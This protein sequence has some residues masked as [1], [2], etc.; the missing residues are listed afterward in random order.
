MYIY[1]QFIPVTTW[2]KIRKLK[3][4]GIPKFVSAGKF[5]NEGVKLNFIVLGLFGSNL[6][7]LFTDNNRIIPVNTV[8]KI[9][10]QVVKHAIFI[11]YIQQFL[12]LITNNNILLTFVVKQVEVLS[13]IHGKGL[14]HGDVKLQN[15]HLDL[16]SANRVNVVDLGF[17]CPVWNSLGED[18]LKENVGTLEY[19]S[20]DAHKGGIKIIQIY[21]HC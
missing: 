20:R 10:Q 3:W 21:V 6:S 4:L 7:D 17:A 16:K 14:I 9:A 2:T 13:F 8:Y 5:D 19:M 12:Q 11:L 18:S 15:L 1:I